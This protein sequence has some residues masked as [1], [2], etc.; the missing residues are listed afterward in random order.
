MSRTPRLALAALAAVAACT[1]A[2]TPLAPPES[3]VAARGGAAA[4]GAYIIRTRADALPDEFAEEV[5]A[6]G[7][8]VRRA[9]PELG[10][11]VAT[12]E[13]ADFA[14]RASR[15]AAVAA[16]IPDLPIRSAEM[17]GAD[18]AV[19][20]LAHTGP[21]NT[22]D[23]PR[24]GLQWPLD[25]I[26]APEAWAL[27]ATGAGARVA[28]LDAGFD[29]AHPDLNDNWDLG[30]ARSFVPGIPLSDDPGSHGTH[31]SGIIAAED[32]EIG[33]LGVAPRATL[34]PIKVLHRGS[35]DLSWAVEAIYYAATRVEAGGAGA[36]VMNMSF[37]VLLTPDE[38][39]L[40]RREIHEVFDRATRYAWQQGVTMVAAAGNES[41]NL[42]DEGKH[43]LHLMSD[44][45]HV[46][47]V[48]ATA[49]SG[50]AL[51]NTDFTRPTTYTNTGKSLVDLAAPGGDISLPFTNPPTFCVIGGVRATCAAFDLVY[52]TVRGV[53]GFNRGTSMASPHVAGVA[54]LVVGQGGG[55]MHPA[56]VG[57]ALRQGA[58][59][60][61]TPGRDEVYGHGFV[62]AH[63]AVLRA[64]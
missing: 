21:V 14:A 26:D 54:A 16:V 35:G 3:P 18:L 41:R 6:A 27:G 57:A 60:L 28:V 49:P 20:P 63:Q 46:I 24:F 8:T 4:S 45:Q 55:A 11:V 44:L 48:S 51:G 43:F 59:D 22:H 42:D 31:V 58:L 36:D 52:S 38:A 50:W 1:D 17:D 23:E 2:P 10:V 40:Y 47:A 19:D 5:R 39:K 34:I 62:N 15:L 12:S 53:Y 32:N 7:G 56:Q 29:L 25:A 37:G 33:V 13:Q 9:F 64:R 61:G 30:A